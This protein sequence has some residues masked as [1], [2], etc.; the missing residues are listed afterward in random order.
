MIVSFSCIYGLFF[1]RRLQLPHKGQLNPHLRP[2]IQFALNGNLSAVGF[3]HKQHTKTGTGSVLEKIPGIGETRRKKLL[4]TFGSVKAIK[5]ADL[6]DL[7]EVLPKNA[8]LSVYHY[9][10]TPKEE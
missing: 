6:Q 2:F 7:E 9:F 4:K 10:R 3:H 5:G 1:F 8:A